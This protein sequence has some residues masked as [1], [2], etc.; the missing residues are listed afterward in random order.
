MNSCKS[1]QACWNFVRATQNIFK[2]VTCSSWELVKNRK[3]QVTVWSLWAGICMWSSPVCSQQALLSFEN[4]ARC[5]SG[6]VGL[7]GYKSKARLVML[8]FSRSAGGKSVAW[9]LTQSFA[10]HLGMSTHYVPLEFTSSLA[11]VILITL[12]GLSLR[13]LSVSSPRELVPLRARNIPRRLELGREPCWMLQTLSW[14][15]QFGGL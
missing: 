13:S 10:W 8:L 4:S 6:K 5:L 2:R 9:F 3:P 14:I 15:S 7:L 12:D 11:V 1:Y